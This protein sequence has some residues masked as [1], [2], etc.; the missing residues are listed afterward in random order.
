[1]NP[2]D[3]LERIRAAFDNLSLRERALV[4]GAGGALIIALFYVGL[5]LPALSASENAALRVSSAEQQLLAM[6]RLRTEYDDVVHRLASVESRIGKDSRGNVRTALENLAKQAD[7]KIESMEP[8][9]S[10]ANDQ[11]RETKVA[12]RLESVTLEQ[13]VKLLHRI[14]T[15]PKQVLS[16]KKLRFQNRSDK[17]QLLNLSFTVSSFERV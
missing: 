12:V 7:V 2:R 11:Y 15:H 1:L 9:A 14:E 13:A 4:S 8:Q 3:L 17:L 5:V 10:P 6:L 16:V